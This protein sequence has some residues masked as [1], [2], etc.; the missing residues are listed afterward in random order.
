MIIPWYQ[1]RRSQ[2]MR[3]L[4]AVLTFALAVMLLPCQG[5]PATFYVKL[6]P[7]KTAAQ[8]TKKPVKK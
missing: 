3:S 8:N 7:V 6:K 2:L 1:S 4:M 5:F